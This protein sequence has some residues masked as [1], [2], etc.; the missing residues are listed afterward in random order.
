MTVRD[1]QTG[2]YR[3]VQGNVFDRVYEEELLGAIAERTG[4]GTAELEEAVVGLE[5]SIGFKAAE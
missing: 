4:A 5:Q 3:V 2:N 1:T